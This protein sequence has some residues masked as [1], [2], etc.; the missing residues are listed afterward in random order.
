[1]S[2]EKNLCFTMLSSNWVFDIVLNYG[3]EVP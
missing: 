3:S 1:M 2:D